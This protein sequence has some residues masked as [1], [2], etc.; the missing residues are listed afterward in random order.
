MPMIR[1]AVL[2]TVLALLAAGCREAPTAP[3]PPLV[4]L[5][6]ELTAGEQQLI[7]GSNT[8]AFSLLRAV[9]AQPAAADS[10]LF[11]SPLSASMALGMTANGAAGTTLDAMRLTLGFGDAPLASIDS[12]Y[13]SLIDLL[14]SLDPNVDFR[15]ANSIWYRQGFPVDS[16]FLGATRQFFDA[17]VA[18]KDFTDPATVTDINDWVNNSTNGK[19]PTIVGAIPAGMVM[20]LLDAIYFKGAWEQ[21]FAN[22]DTRDGPFTLASGGTTT[23]PFMRLGHALP[24]AETATYQ[25]VDLGYGRGAYAMTVLLPKPGT[26]VNALVASMDGAAWDG[27]V[28]QLDSAMVVLSL[29]KFRLAWEDSLNAPLRALGMGIAFVPGSADFTAMSPPPAGHDLYI[30]TM[31]QKTFVD[32]NE[33]GTEAAAATSVGVG[34][35]SVPAFVEMRVDHPF[36]FAIR[37]RL[38]GTI[39]FIGKIMR[40]PTE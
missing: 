38:T 9:D 19:I 25:A 8:F 27:L 3:P 20:Y 2:G 31:E 11:L 5:P 10:N 18:E 30:S 39:L 36:V 6:R 29:P 15:I 32:V 21:Q 13:R 24:Y 14:R 34:V 40:P 1:Q 23:V 26:D 17:T 33:E 37:E 16:S 35:T 7:A 4:A 12:S 22:E 28:Q